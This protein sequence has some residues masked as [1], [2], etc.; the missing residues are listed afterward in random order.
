MSRFSSIRAVVEAGEQYQ[1]NTAD[2]KCSSCGECCADL[3]PLS[4]SEVE[5]LRKYAEKHHLKEHTEATIF[6]RE[7]LDLTCPFRNHAEKKCDVYPVRPL[8]CRKFI[9]S[10]PLQDAKKDRDLLHESRPPRSLRWEIFGNPSTLTLLRPTI[11]EMKGGKQRA[12]QKLH[13]HR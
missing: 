6:D 12:Y 10:T 11:N 2:G 1:D 8:I 5:R 7:Y 3:L 13:Q 9:C 4:D